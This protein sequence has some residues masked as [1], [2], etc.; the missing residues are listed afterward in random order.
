MHLGTRC[1]LVAHNA[2][3]DTPRLLRLISKHGMI[4]EFRVIVGFADTLVIFK[5]VLSD[6]KGPGKFKL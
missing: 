3:F 2:S 4:N 1:L 6:R 5:K